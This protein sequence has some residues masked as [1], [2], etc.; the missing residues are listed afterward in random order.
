MK[1]V[2]TKEW[3]TKVSLEDDLLDPSAGSP[4]IDPAALAEPQPTQVVVVPK[5]P[6]GKGARK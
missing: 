2:F 3:V 6:V 4:R 5:T 1:F